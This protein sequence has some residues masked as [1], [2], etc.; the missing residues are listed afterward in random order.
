MIFSTMPLPGMHHDLR[1]FSHDDEKVPTASSTVDRLRPSF[2]QNGVRDECEKG[3][4]PLRR[5]PQGSRTGT[6]TFGRIN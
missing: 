3:P 5:C 2:V 4:A 1:K 6:A